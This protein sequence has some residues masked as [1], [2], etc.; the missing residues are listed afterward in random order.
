[1]GMAIVVVV[2]ATGVVNA[3]IL[4]GS[5]HALVATGYGQLL[6]LKTTL[7][8]VMLSF[9]VV[10]RLWLTPRLALPIWNEMQGDALRRLTRNSMF[11]IALALMIFAIVGILGTLH[12]AIHAF[13]SHTSMQ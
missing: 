5:L 4:V 11:E 10:N 3:W 12:P 9:A 1:M 7:F 13:A 8:A 2:F 6:M